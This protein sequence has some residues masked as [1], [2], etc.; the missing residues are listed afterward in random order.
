MRA[1]I[2]ASAAEDPDD[3]LRACALSALWPVSLTVSELLAALTPRRNRNLWGQYHQFLRHGV[4]AGL[5]G[6]DL[7]QALKGAAEGVAGAAEDHE[8]EAE[9]VGALMEKALTHSTVPGVL[10]A[11]VALLLKPLVSGKVLC[12][13]S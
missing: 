12:P 10:E 5:A 2:S 6:V 13:I 1:L 11:L 4:V 7:P 9:L 3:G 8:P